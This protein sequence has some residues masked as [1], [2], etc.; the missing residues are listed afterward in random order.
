MIRNSTEN[1][2]VHSALLAVKP[3]HFFIDTAFSRSY[4]YNLEIFDSFE[5][6]PNVQNI[7]IGDGRILN[8]KGI[9]KV[10]HID[11]IYY[12]PYLAFNFLSVID[13]LRLDYEVEFSKNICKIFNR[14]KKCLISI[15]KGQDNLYSI[16]IEQL[17]NLINVEESQR[18]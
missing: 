8:A 11:K 4:I 5:L 14:H 2:E 16:D 15:P 6:L 18:D 13:L 10:G 3:T 1:L 7:E 9:G 17:R 12:S